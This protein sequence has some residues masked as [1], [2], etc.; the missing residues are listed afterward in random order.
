MG[1]GSTGTAEET[2]R[3]GAVEEGV[4]A[5]SDIRAE[6]LFLPGEDFLATE[7]LL[8]VLWRRRQACLLSLGL[9]ILQTYPKLAS[10]IGFARAIDDYR[11][12]EFSRRRVLMEHPAVRIWLKH[13]ARLPRV[14]DRGSVPEGALQRHL[15]EFPRLLAFAEILGQRDFKPPY[16]VQRYD[17]DPLVAEAAPPSFVFDNLETRRLRDASSRY[18][19]EFAREVIDAALRRT[20]LVWPECVQVFPKFVKVIIHVP[21]TEFRSCSAE[22][23]AGAIML[24]TEED[25]LLAVEE[26]LIHECGHQILYCVM[27]LDPIIR[28]DANGTFRLPWSG[29]QRDA[30]GYFHATYI[31]LILAL[32][33][34]RALGQLPYDE[35]AVSERLE[36]ILRGLEKAIGDFENA[37]CFTSVGSRFCEKLICRATELIQRN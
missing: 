19:V 32:F 11:K 8:D 15:A 3:E 28:K 7:Q 29:A 23:Y 25:T 14:N 36:A 37:D 5:I 17:V 26:S 21:N 18:T 1:V 33:F 30:Y 20:Q 10:D 31:Y 6:S 24:S 34:E 16:E 4:F 9:S 12:L 13:M 27:E 2:K 22:R 35:A